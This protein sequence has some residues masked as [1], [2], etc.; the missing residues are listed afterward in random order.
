MAKLRFTHQKDI[1]FVIEFSEFKVDPEENQ[2]VSILQALHQFQDNNDF[3]KETATPHLK[4]YVL[5]YG[6]PKETVLR[7]VL[8]V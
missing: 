7:Y 2:T 1:E 6:G 8:V 4:G 5:S 3:T